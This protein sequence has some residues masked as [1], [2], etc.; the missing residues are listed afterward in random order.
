MSNFFAY[1]LGA[2]HVA[3]TV[4]IWNAAITHH[5]ATPLVVLLSWVRISELL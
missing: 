1:C 2:V 4:W 3:R 5:N